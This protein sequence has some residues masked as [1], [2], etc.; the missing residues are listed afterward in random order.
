[1]HI[2]L[3]KNVVATACRLVGGVWRKAMIYDGGEL[4]QLIYNGKLPAKR[5]DSI[6]FLRNT[7]E[8]Y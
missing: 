1:L 7:I 5:N 3:L 4:L 6:K 2:V 8:I